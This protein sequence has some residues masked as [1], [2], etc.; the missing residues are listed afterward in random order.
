MRSADSLDTFHRHFVLP[1]SPT[2]A[3]SISEL[4]LTAPTD[5]MDPPSFIDG[6]KRPIPPFSSLSSSQLGSLDSADPM[7]YRRAPEEDRRRRREKIAKLHRFLGSRV[8]TSLV[9]GFSASDDALPALDRTND[10]VRASRHNRRRSSSATETRSNWF[11]PDDR[12]KEELDEREKAINVRRAI[13]ME[14]VVF[15]TERL[16]LML[17]I[18]ARC[19]AYNPRKHCITPDIL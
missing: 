4:S 2:D 6:D 8:P 16:V 17:T 1:S 18:S 15:I 19:L 14:K 10:N 11:G 12:M 9:L 5:L 3:L 13:K 7:P